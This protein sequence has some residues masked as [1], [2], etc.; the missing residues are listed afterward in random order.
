MALPTLQSG[1]LARESPS[2]SSNA[3]SPGKHRG[4]FQNNFIR[5]IIFEILK[6]KIKQE[7][8]L[9]LLFELFSIGK[10][11]PEQSN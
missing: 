10:R 5:F 8:D 4:F 3:R 11:K 7:V 9:V 2:F 1:F 6:R